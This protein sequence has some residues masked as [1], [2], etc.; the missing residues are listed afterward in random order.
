MTRAV[1]VSKPAAPNSKL[2]SEKKSHKNRVK[3]EGATTACAAIAID[4]LNMT[5]KH[6]LEK[7]KLQAKKPVSYE[8]LPIAESLPTLLS[9]LHE[10]TINKLYLTEAQMSDG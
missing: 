6:N 10:L 5:H 1:I 9:I 7:K 2:N 4:M 3:F 8:Y